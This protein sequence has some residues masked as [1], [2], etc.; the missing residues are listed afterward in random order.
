M[1]DIYTKF[2]YDETVYPQITTPSTKINNTA[3]TKDEERLMS[4]S[5]RQ[6]AKE[7]IKA[8]VYTFKVPEPHKKRCRVVHACKINDISDNKPPSY[9][10]KAFDEVNLILSR[11]A[12]V[13]QFDA[14]SMYNQ[15]KLSTE[16]GKYFAFKTREGQFACLTEMPMGYTNA[17]GV[18]QS[19]SLLITDA[20]G[21]ST[22]WIRIDVIVHLD[23]YLY[24]FSY[25]TSPPTQEA[26]QN[27]QAVVVKTITEFFARTME[28][29]LQL[30]EI[31][32]EGIAQF[33]KGD[34]HQKYSK[35]LELAPPS[36]TFLGVQYDLVNNTRTVAPK[37][38][39]KL[40]AITKV[41]FPE[42]KLNPNT[43]P[44]HLAMLFGTINWIRRVCN[45]K[46]VEFNMTRNT[47]DLAYACWARPDLWD[48]PLEPIAFL[49]QDAFKICMLLINKSTPIYTP[50]PSMRENLICITDASAYGWGAYVCSYSG[51]RWDFKIVQQQWPLL[52]G[53][54][55]KLYE[56]STVAEPKA[57]TELMTQIVVPSHIRHITF[58]SDHAPLV[59]A[60]MST[61][62][63]CHS[64]F[65]TL[66]KLEGQS[67]TFSFLFIAGKHNIA[68][69]P[70]RGSTRGITDRNEITNIIA[71]AGMGL[72]KALQSPSKALPCVTGFTD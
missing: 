30:N 20:N 22:I 18:A 71:G 23:N 57:V 41:V 8:T 39:Q 1:A 68:D 63:R 58:V 34:V 45:I 26:Q 13:V 52:G 16:V 19:L 56:S 29:D 46:N 36:F 3:L 67:W 55:N 70:S 28:A 66:A 9:K 69:G 31:D 32:R 49:F 40:D 21:N 5:W 12:L 2:L 62:A 59:Q 15:F 48:K 38:M 43:T 54:P 10:L 42:G 35:I 72:A 6:I 17:C 51:H 24:A 44:R 64:Y 27:L 37:T 65:T 53:M 11:A 14:V 25:T 61:Q 50:M 7:D 60:S 4:G 33:M 47:A